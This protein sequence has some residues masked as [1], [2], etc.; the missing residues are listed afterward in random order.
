MTTT[1]DRLPAVT[2]A[3]SVSGPG[4]GYWTYKEYAALPDDGHHYEIVNGVLYMTPS[5][6]IPHQKAVLRFSLHLFNHVEAL[7]LGQVFVAPFDV[8]LA[9]NVIIQPDVAVVLNAGLEKVT[10]SRIIGAPD[11]VVEVASPSTAG[12]D[13][14]VKQ[15]AYARA[16]VPEYWI[17]DPVAYT[18]EVLVLEAG[19]YRS[20]DI[21]RGRAKLPSKVI[22]NL[23]VRVEQFFASN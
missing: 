15:D 9:S 21:F 17:A 14:R 22:A 23:P 18:V 16:G 1:S 7:G 2:S 4:Q 10:E 20:L 6:S 11:L 12:Y 3:D 8:E 19:S 5:P 13:R